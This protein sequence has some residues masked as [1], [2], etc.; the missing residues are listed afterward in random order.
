MSTAE[1]MSLTDAKAAVSAKRSEIVDAER[2]LAGLGEEKRRRAAA[3]EH[4][5]DLRVAIADAEG[6]LEDLREQLSHANRLCEQARSTQIHHERM[7]ALARIYRRD[8]AYL[9]ARKVVLEANRI[10][11]A[12]QSQLNAFLNDVGERTGRTPGAEIGYL[13]LREPTGDL[14]ALGFGEIDGALAV[15]PLAGVLSNGGDTLEQVEEEI[16]RMRALAV[17]AETAEATTSGVRET[18]TSELPC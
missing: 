3:G 2:E 16:C 12:A 5:R 15:A 18:M 1:I 11:A 7:R 4:T 9:H 6:D 17:E 13:R 10:L 8:V 14:L